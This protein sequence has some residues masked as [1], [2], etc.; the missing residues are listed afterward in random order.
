MDRDPAIIEAAQAVGGITKLSTQL[1][2]SRVAASAWKRVPA[3][4]VLEV[5]RLT[6]VSRHKLRPDLYPEQ[7]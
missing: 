5:E 4:R 2:L 1:G 7:A 6:G 3:E